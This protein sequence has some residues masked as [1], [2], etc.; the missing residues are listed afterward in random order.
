MCQV[1]AKFTITGHEGPGRKYKCSSTLS[2]TSALDEGGCLTPNLGRFTPENKPVPILQ[3]AEWAPGPVWT[4]AETSAHQVF[5][6]RTV[7]P[8]AFNVLGIYYFE[9]KIMIT[10]GMI[11]KR[12]LEI[13]RT[14]TNPQSY[15]LIVSQAEN[16]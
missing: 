2:L 9:I 8:V 5:D 12:R 4:G 15:A 11:P 14:L 10:T 7:Q 13:N 3:E 16:N 1:R 6:L